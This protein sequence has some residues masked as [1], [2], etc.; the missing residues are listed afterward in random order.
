MYDEHNPLGG[1]GSIAIR[2][3]VPGAVSILAV[4]IGL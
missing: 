1:Y 4:V 2:T 3:L